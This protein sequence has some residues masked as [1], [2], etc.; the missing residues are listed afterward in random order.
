MKFTIYGYYYL[1]LYFTVC[2]SFGYFG[3]NLILFEIPALSWNPS[4]HYV[5]SMDKPRVLYFPLFSISSYYDLPH[6]WSMFYPLHDRSYFTTPQMSLIDRNF[7][8]LNTT[9]ENAR[10]NNH[11]NNNN[12]NNE[13]NFDFEM[14]NLLNPAAHPNN[15]IPAVE[16]NRPVN[17]EHVPENLIHEEDNSIHQN[18]LRNS[19]VRDTNLESIAAENPVNQRNLVDIQNLH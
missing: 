6:F 16:N 11:I 7:I 13:L 12:N 10:Q 14:Q 18:L 3:L 8:L 19:Q 15:P 5:P 4:Y 1:A 2:L 17:V 9:M